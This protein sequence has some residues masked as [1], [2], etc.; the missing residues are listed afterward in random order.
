MPR[1]G[2]GLPARV[3]Q[4]FGDW[5]IRSRAANLSGPST[6]EDEPLRAELFSGDQMALHG[7]RLAS[8]HVLGSMGKPDQLLKRLTSNERVLVDLGKRLA[9]GADAE[10]RFTPA[11]EWLLDNFYL[12]EEEIRTARRHLPRGYSRELPRLAHG[13]ADGSASDLPRVYHL[14]LQVIAHGDGLSGA[15]R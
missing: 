4:V 10:R 11:A 7:K 15:A 1:N 8:L 3:T 5:W 6:A 2:N 12:I 13:V 9:A 14:A